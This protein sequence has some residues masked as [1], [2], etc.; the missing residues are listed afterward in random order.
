ML[1]ML[2]L[3]IVKRYIYLLISFMSFFNFFVIKHAVPKSERL[4]FEPTCYV[5]R[6]KFC[7]FC[8]KVYW[9]L[10]RSICN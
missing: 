4:L 9:I 7:N 6:V 8:R 2:L 5:F 10:L 1:E 3:C